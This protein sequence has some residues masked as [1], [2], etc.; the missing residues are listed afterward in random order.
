[1][2]S[3][4]WSWQGLATFPGSTAACLLITRLLHQV[5]PHRLADVPEVAVSYSVALALLLVA[6][7]ALDKEPRVMDYL[8]CLIN[9]V[10]VS[11]TVAGGNVLFGITSSD[12]R[13]EVVRAR[14]V[15][16]VT[17]STTAEEQSP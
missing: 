8:L 11:V 4:F 3:G 15:E 13:Q 5:I 2:N 10:A 16:R 1:M 12:P 9:A 7:L 6:T 14:P 17:E